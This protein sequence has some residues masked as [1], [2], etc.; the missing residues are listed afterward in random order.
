LKLFQ[1]INL[2]I[3]VVFVTACA[4]DLNIKSEYSKATNFNDFKYYSWTPAAS[5]TGTV[6]NQNKD[7]SEDENQNQI[8]TLL[9]QNIRFMIDQQLAAK[10]MIKQ[11]QGPV[12]FLV[13]YNVG[14]NK[15]V[16]LKTQV[17]RENYA[18]D[19]QT[20]STFGYSGQFYS[21]VMT[22]VGTRNREELMIDRYREGTMTLDFFEPTKNKLIWHAVADKR[23]DIQALPSTE[24]D[25]LIEQVIKELLAKFPPK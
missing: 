25:E 18:E 3:M 7:N 8:S 10:G 5:E 24:R 21:G 13:D 2:L 17:V 12:D 20:Y 15:R 22:T 14:V 6:L 16:D 4:S 9:D 19:F 11:E 23:L 1:R